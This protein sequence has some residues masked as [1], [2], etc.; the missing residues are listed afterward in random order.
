MAW[1]DRN[2]RKDLENAVKKARRVAEAGAR[3]AVNQLAVGHHEPWSVLSPDQ[4][5]LRNRLRAHGRQL[6]DKLDEKNGTQTVERLTGECAYEHW[7]RLLFA[8]FLAENDLLVEPESGMALSLDECRELAREQSKDWLVLASDFAQ[9]MLPQIFRAGDPVLEVAFPPEKRQE[10]EAIL[11]G[12]PRDVFIADDSLGWVYQFWQA[13]QKDAVNKSQKRVGAEELPA[14]TQLFTEPYMVQF[15][16]QNSLG[17]WWVA[18]GRALPSPMPYLRRTERG[19]PAAGAFD[20]WPKH[21]KDLRVLDPSCGSGHF[22]VAAFQILV[23]F[24]VAEEHMSAREAC[25]AVLRDNL[26]G[27]ELDPRCTQIAV[28]ALAFA[29]WR[30]PGAEGWRLLPAMHVAC[31]GLSIASKEADWIDLAQGDVKLRTGMQRLYRLFRE[32]P[33]LGSLINPRSLGDTLFEAPFSDLHPL[34]TRAATRETSSDDFRE[35]AVAVQGVAKSAEVLS[36]EFTLVVTNVPYLGRAKQ[37]DLLKKFC[38]ATYKDA[39]A[40]LAT[41]FVRRCLELTTKGGVVA[42]VTPQ[43][44]LTLGSYDRLRASL[45]TNVTWCSLANLGPRAFETITGHIVNVTLVTLQNLPAGADHTFPGINAADE[46]TP[47]AKEAALRE[48]SIQFLSQREQRN[49]PE[50][51]VAFHAD[52]RSRTL[53][54]FAMMLEGTSRGDTERFDRC[55]WEL[56][57]LDDARWSPLLN[58]PS[59]QAPY[60]GRE[61]VIL[62]ERGEGELARSDG[63]RIRGKDAW[64]RPSVFVARSKEVKA[65]LSCGEIHAQNGAALI[66]KRVEDLA[67][68]WAFCTSDEFRS[69][70]RRL[71]TKVIVPSGVFTAIPFDRDRWVREAEEQFGSVLPAPESADPSQWLFVGDPAQGEQPLLVAL[72]RL[73]GYRWP[74]QTGASFPSAK[75]VT[76]DGLS[77]LVD[78][79]G[80]VCLPAL[81]GEQSAA[82]RLRSLLARAYGEQ[83]SG[84]RLKS[85]LDAVEGTPSS[86][87]EWLLDRAFD[88]HCTFFHQT[89]FVFHVWDGLRDGFGAFVNYHRLAAPNGEGRRTLEKVIYTYLGDWLDRQRADQKSGVEGADGRVAAAEHLKRELEKILDGEAP[90]DVFVRWKPLY[91]QAVGWEPDIA[92]GVRANIRPFM[93]A[94]PLNA[95]GKNACIL[96]VTPRVKWDKDKG[97][98]PERDKVDYPWFWGW[99]ESTQDF[100]GG[101]EFDGNRW[102]DLHYTR[103]AKL[104]ARER[105]KGGKS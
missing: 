59:R 10:L 39:R 18:A 9:R 92:D 6:G 20:A 30:F 68:L 56:E 13:D 2:L 60:H 75:S 38:D 21:A 101:K 95:R 87:E 82:D 76:D 16:L 86:V 79:D 8:R 7:H 15:L 1:L 63:A 41:C 37:N 67:A 103:A 62:W 70:V 90:Y 61:H 27:L 47:T 71:S 77:D 54:D 51:R 42:A 72:A 35:M 98:E 84:A 44:W 31:S 11:E 29:A 100:A 45:L 50:S 28:F 52:V 34:L 58:S 74:R 14:V 80:I 32:G 96:R 66:P 4:R 99:D 40:D 81:K 85:L 12:L 49:S 57:R 83:W 65:T 105:A 91:L 36:G 43:H 93:T 46:A 94:K 88:Q 73:C 97:L 5:K 26:F 23:A 24:R 89:P 25:D 33:T 102:N 69:S 19:T 3:D 53:G 17:A 55:F 22:L 48:Q 78:D 104:A 64:G